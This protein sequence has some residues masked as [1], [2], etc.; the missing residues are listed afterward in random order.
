MGAELED[1]TLEARLQQV[2]QISEQKD[3]EKELQAIKEQLSSQQAGQEEVE[4]TL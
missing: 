4:K 1:S 2:R 3:A